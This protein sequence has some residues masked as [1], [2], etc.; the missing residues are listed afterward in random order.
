[1]NPIL[2]RCLG[3]SPGRSLVMTALAAIAF[4][5]AASTLAHAQV[6]LRKVAVLSTIGD[7][8]TVV[9]SQRQTGSIINTNERSQTPVSTP[10]FDHS[11]L[12][13]TSR[14]SKQARPDV[15]VVLLSN[16][17]PAAGS[18]PPFNVEGDQLSRHSSL[19]PALE[20][21]GATHVLLIVKHRAPARLK[22]ADGAS[23]SGTLEGLGFYVDGAVRTTVVATGATGIGFVAPYAYFKLLLVDLQSLKVVAERSV[24]EST[25]VS[26]ALVKEG[27][28]PWDALTIEEKINALKGLIERAIADA[29]PALYGR[30]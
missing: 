28:D 26:A 20:K 10:I 24:S 4:A 25:A 9:A 15:E 17:K 5:M 2:Q 18:P 23:G 16:P 13:A 29:V 14:A 3:R 19:L 12:L 7:V 27:L 11:A 21:T 22:F 1:M 6:T 30:Q 8:M